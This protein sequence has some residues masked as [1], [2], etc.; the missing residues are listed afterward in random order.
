MAAADRT[1]S[2]PLD[3]FALPAKAGCNAA[4]ADP[5]QVFLDP[6]GSSSLKT[7]APGSLE[8]YLQE[9]QHSNFDV[10]YELQCANPGAITGIDFPFFDMFPTTQLLRVRIVSERGQFAFD[11]QRGH[12]HLD[13]AGDF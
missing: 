8:R 4:A 9:A 2:H 13:L 1:L 11:V 10:T 7:A 3:L 6:Q 5:Q 12:A